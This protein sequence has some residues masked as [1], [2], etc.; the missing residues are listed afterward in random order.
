MEVRI[1]VPLNYT[2]LYLS[3]QSFTIF[4]WF[5]LF[6]SLTAYILFLLKLKDYYQDRIRLEVDIE[7]AKFSTAPLD[8]Y[9]NGGTKIEFL[10]DI[11]N[12]GKQPTTI[13][14]V[15]FLSDNPDFS[16]FD[17]HNS[18][19]YSPGEGPS[20]YFKPIRVDAN[21]RTNQVF[22]LMKGNSF[23]GWDEL[24]CTVNF[25]TS[26]NT[27]VRNVKVNRVNNLN[28]YEKLPLDKK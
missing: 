8:G 15:N 9:H 3:I 13:S 1:I 2:A 16:D 18:K 17:L 20:S 4:E 25:E 10:V 27:I 14:K 21:D 24:N 7:S 28:I 23:E 11:R 12:E 22:T 6:G 26:H 19:A 5:T